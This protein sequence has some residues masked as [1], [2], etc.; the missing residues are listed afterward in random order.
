MYKIIGFVGSPVGENSYTYQ[1]TKILIDY[2]AS[3]FDRQIDSSIYNP[4]QLNIRECVGCENCF[5]KGQCKINDD[6]DIIKKEIKESDIIIFAS[7]VYCHQVSGSMKIFIDRLALWLHT[8]ELKGKIGISINTSY[9]NGNVFVED[10][11]NKI[12][13]CMGA[14]VISSVSLKRIQMMNENSYNSIIRVKGNRI[15][16]KLKSKDILISTRQETYF[17]TLSLSMKESK[18]KS[19]EK[20]YWLQNNYFEYSSFQQLFQDNCIFLS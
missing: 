15:L 20:E 10:Y 6:L 5:N 4:K 13:E 14:Y 8:M 17:K 19:Y 3:E 16:E 18:S 7:P 9:N 12:L 11:L 2:I 1:A